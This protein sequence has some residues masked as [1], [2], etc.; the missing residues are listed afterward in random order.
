MKA[1]Y[2]FI[3]NL[4]CLIATGFQA[5]R[6]VCEDDSS[7]VC[8]AA[9]FLVA[10]LSTRRKRANRR[11]MRC[12]LTGAARHP[13]ARPHAIHCNTKVKAQALFERFILL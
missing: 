13:H 1:D 2:N 5:F 10:A 4:K 7:F 9:L 6:L 8:A 12:C 11:I 3:C